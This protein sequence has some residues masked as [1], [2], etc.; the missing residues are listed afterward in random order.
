M[1]NQCTNLNCERT[2][3]KQAK[4]TNTINKFL[5]PEA[6]CC[7]LQLHFDTNDGLHMCTKFCHSGYQLY[8]VSTLYWSLS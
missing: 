3:L 6:V 4:G 5:L 7:C 1:V 8:L 2:H